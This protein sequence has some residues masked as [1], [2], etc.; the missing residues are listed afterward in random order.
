M[1]WK[2]WLYSLGAAAIKAGSD[3]ALLALVAPEMSWRLIG[4][5]VAI[6]SL[7]SVLHILRESPLPR[8]EWTEA[9]REAKTLPK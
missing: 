9:E 6:G 8:V 5:A 3:A 7:T 2:A 1:R 4:T